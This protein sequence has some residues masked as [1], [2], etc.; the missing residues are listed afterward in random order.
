G[1][2]AGAMS[3]AFGIA[4][5]ADLEPQA[6]RAVQGD[7]GPAGG[8]GRPKRP[9]AGGANPGVGGQVHDPVR[10]GSG[11]PSRHG[12]APRSDGRSRSNGSITA[13]QT[14][15]A[16]LENCCVAML[17]ST[18]PALSPKHFFSCSSDWKNTHILMP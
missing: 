11:T 18:V 7:D 15:F 6:Y 8:G 9:G 10:A 3:R 13:C 17:S 4:A 16:A 2:E 1:A 12:A 14:G 5:A